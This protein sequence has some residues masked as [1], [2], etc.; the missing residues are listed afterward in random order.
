M[1][2][3][4]VD[5]YQ[6]LEVS[7]DARPDEIRRAYFR[8]AKLYHPDLSAEAD[9]SEANERFLLIQKAYEILS[10]T[11][12]RLDYDETRRKGGSTGEGGAASAERNVGRGPRPAW[13]RGPSLEEVRDARRAYQR[14]DKLLE[15]EDVE[16]AAEVLRVINKTVPNEAEYQS[17]YG[18]VLALQGDNLHKARDLCRRAVQAEPF[19]A[20]FHAQLGFVYLQA[21]LVKTSQECFRTALAY[22]PTHELAV[23]YQDG[24]DN[25]PR[26]GGLLGRLGSLFGR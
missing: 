4:D 15:Q 23:R 13:L 22:D 16:R 18:Y 2:V 26:G 20:D 6:V 8:L 7:P 12:R 5:L 24:V 3:K 14:I 1:D 25:G 11:D 9:S 10:H 21:G 19:N 17:K